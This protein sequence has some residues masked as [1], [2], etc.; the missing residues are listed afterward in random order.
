MDWCSGGS[1][2][3]RAP[4]RR[5]R[6]GSASP[7][8]RCR[9]RGR[10]SRRSAGCRSGPGRWKFPSNS[11]FFVSML[12]TG[13][14]A[15]WYSCRSRAMFS[16]WALRSGC[17]PI[18]FFLR[19]VRRPSLSCPQQ[20]ANRPPT[21]GRAQRE[22]PPRQLAQRQVGPQHA[23]PH[24]IARREFR[25][26]L[27][28]VGLQGGTG[29]RQRRRPPLFF[30]PGRPPDPR[31]LPSPAGPAESSSDRSQEAGDVLDAA[32]PQLGRLDGGIPPAVLLGQ[33]TNNRFIFA[34]TSTE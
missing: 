15:A 20:A 29:L 8:P 9:S 22:Q 34:S 5:C 4:G 30:G 17:C 32:V 3:A 28:Q 31:V 10:T 12:I 26:Q 33:P 27:P 25:E 7:C 16:N 18:V 23:D 19:A 2:R 14:P 24:R 6:A 13:S 1:R 11:F 21:G